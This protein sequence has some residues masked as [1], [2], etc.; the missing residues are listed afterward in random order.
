MS[1]RRP[2]ADLVVA[3]VGNTKVDVVVFASGTLRTRLRLPTHARTQRERDARRRAL[4]AAHWDA[5]TPAILASVAPRSGAWVERWLRRASRRVHVV[6]WNDPWPFRIA[7]RTPQSVGVDRLA[8]VAGMVARGWSNGIAVDAGT[9]TTID[10][11][12][13]GVF[14]G[15]LIL[16]GPALQLGALQQGTDLLPA[17][18]PQRVV[19][20]VGRDTASALRAGAWYGSQHAIAGVVR[21]LRR[22]LGAATPVVI[23]G[24]A[25]D[26]ACGVAGRTARD[27]D[28]LVHGL[29]RLAAGLPH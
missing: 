27:P 15:G 10:V 9:A 29:R 2:G 6:R 19:P 8:N 20:L 1:V 26:L 12:R 23:T 5:A 22:E 18:R 14:V 11:L 24:G 13:R 16:A 25:A 7:V 21:A 4:R 17:I 28:L 3:D